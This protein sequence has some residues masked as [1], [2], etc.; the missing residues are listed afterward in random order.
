M[1][2]FMRLTPSAPVPDDRSGT[3]PFAD[4]MERCLASAHR[5]KKAR[6]KVWEDEGGSLAVPAPPAVSP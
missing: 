6:L 2:V 4:Q 1:S 5:P 3:S